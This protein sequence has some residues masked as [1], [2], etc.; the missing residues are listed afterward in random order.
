MEKR[1]LFPTRAGNLYLL[2]CIQTGSV[3]HPTSYQVG[4]GGL[5]PRVKRLGHEVDYSLPATAKVKN[6]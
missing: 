4:T 1:V 6:V 5:F 2:H 3:D